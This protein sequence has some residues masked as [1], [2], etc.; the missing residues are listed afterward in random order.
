M[1]GCWNIRGLNGSKK[2][3]NVHDWIV[4]NKLIAVGL[5]ETKVSKDN[6][7]SVEN[8]LNMEN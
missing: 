4:K 8:G 2:Q 5:L 6:I 7:M 1:L 3:K